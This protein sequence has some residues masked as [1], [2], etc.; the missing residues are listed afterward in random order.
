MLGFENSPNSS[1][2][3][4]GFFDICLRT[5]M[6]DFL[7]TEKKSCLIKANDANK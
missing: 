1:T 6:E 2:F 4:Q 7:F 5:F 3:L